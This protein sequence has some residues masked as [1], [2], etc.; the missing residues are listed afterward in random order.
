VVTFLLSLWL[1]LD[2]QG[3][4]TCPTPGEVSHQL[5]RLVPEGK[6][7][8]RASRAY[9]SAGDGFVN[10]ELLDHQGGLMSERRLDRSGSCAELAEAVA[11]ILAAWQAQ[12]S[13]TVSPTAMEPSAPTSVLAAP[14]PAQTKPA[15]LFDAGIAALSSIVDG[16][17]AWGAKLEGSLTPFPHG[18]GFHVAASLSSRHTRSVEALP[19]TT[20]E[21]RWLRPALAAGPNLRLQGNRLALDIHG[22][23]VLALL[24][25]NG[26]GLGK[27]TSDTTVQVGMAAGLR[28]L[29]TW[30]GGA[31][32][33]GAD[34]FGYPGQ[35]NLTIGDERKGR[36]PHLEI[37]ASLGIAM[38]RYR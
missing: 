7:S 16:Q 27:S 5:A 19:S 23:A 12:L 9:L 8:E 35:D 1:A 15:V 10:I 17:A 14:F 34:L 30:T 20:A 32:W 29:W 38:G 4:L 18:L 22:N 24:H 28:G 21:A 25:I 11:V 2:I 26:S 33:V 31:V 13:P 6:P 36:L 3:T 37:Q